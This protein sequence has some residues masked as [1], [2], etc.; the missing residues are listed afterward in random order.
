[1]ALVSA[2]DGIFA[3]ALPS[4]KCAIWGLGVESADLFISSCFGATDGRQALRS[5]SEGLVDRLT[6]PHSS[7]GYLVADRP[8]D[9]GDRMTVRR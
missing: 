8:T 6:K 1:M 3:G 2:A 4:Y 7:P 9:L 5:V